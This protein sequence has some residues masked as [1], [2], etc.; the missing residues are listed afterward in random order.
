[1]Q[2]WVKNLLKV[3]TFRLE[4][5]SNPWP[6]GLYQ[7]ATTSHVMYVYVI[8]YTIFYNWKLYFTLL[9]TVTQC[10]HSLN[11]CYLGL[12]QKCCVAVTWLVDQLLLWGLA[13]YKL[14]SFF[15]FCTNYA[16]VFACYKCV[17]CC[18][19]CHKFLFR[20]IFYFN[21][22]CVFVWLIESLH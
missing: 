5:E 6:F 7:S 10:N 19:C 8:Y 11:F 9:H 1:M 3:L 13:W 18:F 21:H 14:V 20:F 17:L 4:R 22:C 12:A 2:L 15:P 16:F